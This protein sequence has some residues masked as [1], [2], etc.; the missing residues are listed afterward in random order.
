MRVS[1]S[2]LESTLRVK[3]ISSTCHHFHI[4]LVLGVGSLRWVRCLQ[5]PQLIQTELSHGFPRLIDHVESI[6]E[7]SSLE[8]FNN[9]DAKLAAA[10]AKILLGRRIPRLEEES[11]NTER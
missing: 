3:L 2:T 9:L 6:E 1:I 4:L 8:G 11:A 7:F 5:L 10:P